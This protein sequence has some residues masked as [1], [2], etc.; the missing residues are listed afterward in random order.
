MVRLQLLIIELN[1]NNFLMVSQFHYGSIT[2]KE[3]TDEIF[4]TIT[5]SQFHYG[6]ITTNIFHE[7]L[8]EKRKES[9][10]HYGSITTISDL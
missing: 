4:D 8:E 2:T 9:Q 3:E 1:P 6:S 10:F 7:W 5:A